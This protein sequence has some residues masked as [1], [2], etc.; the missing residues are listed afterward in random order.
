MPAFILGREIFLQIVI[1][2]NVYFPYVAAFDL[3]HPFIQILMMI[4]RINSQSYYQE[5][6]TTTWMYNGA[7]HQY[8]FAIINNPLPDYHRVAVINL[9]MTSVYFVLH[10]NLRC[11]F[12][13]SLFVSQSSTLHT[14]RRAFHPPYRMA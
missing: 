5:E 3:T 13:L 9:I 8:K 11:V 10:I 14:R 6:K 7:S 1:D 2:A 12:F 4:K